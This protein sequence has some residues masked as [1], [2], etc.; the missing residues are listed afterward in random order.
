ME[1]SSDTPRR[2]RSRLLW[3][4]DAGLE[5]VEYALIAALLL[6]GILVAVPAN[7]DAFTDAYNAITNAIVSAL[8]GP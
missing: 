3:R 5:A 4:C 1:C 7:I 8:G 6:G 2:A